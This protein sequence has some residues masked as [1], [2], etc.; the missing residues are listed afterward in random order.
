MGGQGLWLRFMTS[1]S[2][3][4]FS[5]SAALTSE[6]LSW[7]AERPR[8]YVEAMETWSTF[9]PKWPIW[10]DA[11]DARLIEVVAPPG[12]RTCDRPV[13]L[14]ARGRAVLRAA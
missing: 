7:A 8:T 6:L 3:Q 11:F 13:R 14:T 10:E 9:C 2:T 4:P 12:V 1:G 5:Q